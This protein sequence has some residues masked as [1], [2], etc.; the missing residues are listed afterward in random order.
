MNDTPRVEAVI[1]TE[2]E[3][4]PSR[5]FYK[6][7]SI[8]FDLLVLARELERE[9]AAKDAY[10][11]RL[12]AFADEAA[13]VHIDSGTMER[14]DGWHDFDAMDTGSMAAYERWVAYLESRKLI[15]RHPTEACVRP[16]P[17][18]DAA[19]AKNPSPSGQVPT[20]ASGGAPQGTSSPINSEAS[21]PVG[22]GPCRECDARQAKIDAL[23]M[24]HCPEE[25]TPE[26][27][28]EW[29]RHQVP[30]ELPGVR[31]DDDD[32]VA[33]GW[34]YYFPSS[35]GHGYVMRQDAG[36]YNGHSY[37]GAQ[38]YYLR[39]SEHP[40]FKADEPKPAS[41]P[42]Q[43]SH[44]TATLAQAVENV[45]PIVERE[46]DAEQFKSGEKS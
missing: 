23:M 22:L 19:L 16:L 34:F 37:V 33:S 14:A 21:G 42:S 20:E 6:L 17:A 38:P 1:G 24:E 36:P 9:S 26:Q 5:D 31:T 11:G 35:W 45:R 2:R 30:S 10:A 25:M 44:V 43:G 39:R 15:E 27:T 29:A 18:L 4:H 32:Y 13:W 12:E 3:L 28:A 46:R 40:I 7:A 8:Y 41:T